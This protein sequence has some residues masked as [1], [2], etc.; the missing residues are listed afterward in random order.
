M[1]LKRVLASAPRKHDAG[2]P[3]PLL[4]PWG[5]VLDPQRVRDEHPHPQFAREHFTILN[6]WWD[7]AIVPMGRHRVIVPPDEF[8]GRILVPFSPESLLSGVGR[9]LQPDEVLWYARR[10]TLDPLR[11]NERCILH[12][13]AVDYACACCVNGRMVGSHEGGYLPFSFDITEALRTAGASSSPEGGV[14]SALVR[15]DGLEAIIAVCVRDPS[16]TGTQLRGKQKLE[17]GGIW[18]TAQSGLWQPVWLE[19]VPER[20][21]ER[22]V[23][24]PRADSGEIAVEVDVRGSEGLVRLYV[25][26]PEGN[27]VAAAT[28]PVEEGVPLSCAGGFGCTGRASAGAEGQE[29]VGENGRGPAAGAERGVVPGAGREAA[30]D[31]PLRRVCVTAQVPDVRLWS[32]EDPVLYDLTVRFG[33]DVV[34]SYTAFRTVEV[35]RAS[36][37]VFRFFLN[38][39]PFL[40]RGVLDQGYWSDGLMTAPDDE[41]FVYD[42]QTMKD[43]GFTMMRKHLKVEADRWY[44]H[45]DRL[46]MLVWQDMV[47]GGGQLSAWETSYKPTLWRHSWGSYDDTRAS[48]REKLG[49]GDERYRRQ[50]RQ[51]CRDTVAYLRNHPSIVAWVLFNEGWGQFD[52]AAA[53]DDVRRLDPMR[54]VDGVS[55]W[56]D[57]HDGDYLSVH[58]YFRP[59]AVYHDDARALKGEAALRGGRAFAISEFGGAVFRVGDHSAFA[60]SYG[61]DTFATVQEW[62]T[63]V[64]RI[65]DEAAALERQGLAGF[66]Y[67]QLSDVEEEVNG[68]LT[69]DRRVNKLKEEPHD[70]DEP[71]R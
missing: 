4:T 7:Y 31:S 26:D 46:G 71:H 44:Y 54:P 24:H 23:L 10:V 56:Y 41:A 67:T 2:A 34:H 20:R 29:A 49:A 17:S 5:E 27:P 12:F 52:A 38:G 16:D 60:Q 57:Q 70:W 53:V 36:D 61:Y 37:G 18:Y 6:G 42:I 13:E 65:V 25:T 15:G 11:P 62:R 32:P 1:D 22:L 14:E 30:S 59:L 33:T 48:H 63:A 8:D 43:A 3:R 50:W 45:C 68:L 47:S 69:Y 40:L 21:V 55:G 51:A 66:V 35:R 58:N 19:I 28:A 9:Q 39:K 64:R